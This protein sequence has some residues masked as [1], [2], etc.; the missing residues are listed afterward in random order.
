MLRIFQYSNWSLDTSVC[1]WKYSYWRIM[2][3]IYTFTIVIKINPKV[4]CFFM[5]FFYPTATCLQKP[6]ML[7]D[8]FLLS[9]MTHLIL[10]IPIFVFLLC[11]LFFKNSLWRSMLR[12][13]STVPS[14]PTGLLHTPSPPWL[15]RNWHWFPL[16]SSSCAFGAQCASYCC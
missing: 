4:I 5:S 11:L 6:A 2:I 1:V 9:L 16:S 10:F 13:R 3:I 14:W 12:C 7:W 8:I 15:I